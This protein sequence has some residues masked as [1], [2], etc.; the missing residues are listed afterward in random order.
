MPSRISS[1]M[2]GS[3]RPVRPSA[4]GAATAT[5]ATTAT[6]VKGISTLS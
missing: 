2:D 6:D 4:S 3:R 1:T 5:A